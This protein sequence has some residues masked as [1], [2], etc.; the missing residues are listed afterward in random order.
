MVRLAA[1]DLDD[2]SRFMACEIGNVAANRHL[3]AEPVFVHLTQAQHPPDL[4][5]G[6]GHVRP[7]G[8]C[9]GV[10][11]GVGM[12]FHSWASAMRVTTPSQPSPIEGEGS[13]SRLGT[14]VMLP[15]HC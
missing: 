14:Y 3:A 7:Q 8:S 13:I 11:A 9:P 12:F 6:L 1:V 2:Q 15:Q 10:G 4:P 5:F